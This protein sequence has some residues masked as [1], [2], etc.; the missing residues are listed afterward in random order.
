MIFKSALADKV[1]V[2]HLAVVEG[3]AIPKMRFVP[4]GSVINHK[5]KTKALKIIS[6]EQEK[7][8]QQVIDANMRLTASAGRWK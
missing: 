3:V 4:S 1:F 5:K 8:I 2:G 7:F 6:Q